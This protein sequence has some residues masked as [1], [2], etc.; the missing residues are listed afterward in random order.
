[1]QGENGEYANGKRKEC[2]YFSREK[3]QTS[4]GSDGRRESILAVRRRMNE[5]LINAVWEAAANA[6]GC[7]I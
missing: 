5:R 4:D 3:D 2:Y 7:N 1:M 6:E